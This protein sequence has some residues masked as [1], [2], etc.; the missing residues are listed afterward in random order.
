MAGA[1]LPDD[2]R[3]RA[4]LPAPAHPGRGRAAR[5]ERGEP[6]LVERPD[7]AR[8]RRLRGARSRTGVIL[9]ANQAFLDLVQ[10]GSEG[11]RSS[12]ERLAAL[13]RPAR[14]RPAGAAGQ[15]A[16]ARSR[17]RVL[18]HAHGELGPR[19]R[20]RS[21][22]SATPTASRGIVALLLRD[23]GPGPRPAP[24]RRRHAGA[25]WAR[26]TGRSARPRCASWSG[27][28]SARSSRHYIEAALDLTRGNRTAAAELLGLSRQSLY[29][30]LDRY[31]LDG[32]HGESRDR[33]ELMSPGGFR[34]G[35]SSIRDLAFGQADLSNCE[36][37]QIHLAGSIQ[38]HGALLVVREPDQAV[39][40]ASAN[41]AAFLGL[42]EEP[43]GPLPRPSSTAT[44]P[45]A[46]GR[47]S[48]SRWT[49]SRSRSAAG[50]ATGTQPFDGLLHRPPEGGL[51]IELER[52]GPPVDLSRQVE[53]GAA[54]ASSP[55]ASL[56][57]LCDE[58]ARIF[59]DLTGYDRVMVYRF[60]ERRPRRGLRRAARSRSS[61]PI[62]GN[63]YPAS[64]IPQIARRLYERNRVRVLVDVGYA[65][66]PL[67]PRLSPVTGRDLDMSLCFLR[68]M[69]P[70]HVQYLKNMGVAATL[71]V[72]AVVGG[73][74]WGLI[75]C[76]HYAPRFVHYEMRAVVRAAG[77]DGG[78]PHRGPRELR[79]GPGRAVRPAPRAAHDRGDLARR[80]LADGA[81]RQLAAAAA[82]AG[83]DRRR[84]PVRG[85]GPH[86]RRGARHAAAARDRRVAGRAAARARHRHGRPWASDEPAFAR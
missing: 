21:R 45:T 41:A 84:A 5:P 4:G 9:R 78:D 81:V 63:R 29:A 79:P 14:C 22:P 44:S 34:R 47:T 28:R 1:R 23:V 16:P 42:A 86:R 3:A 20:S 31:G 35:F 2:G 26:C 13:A 55:A 19:P 43:V 77:R 69:S 58:T 52:A 12:G 51:V 85:P 57:A 72:L 56:R 33:P 30:K 70:I 74:L 25:A 48:A 24:G 11:H 53:R 54:D 38:P 40:Q 73:R 18:D 64:D 7:R 75:A 15:R 37:E 71:V 67:R 39:V 27:T 32:G 61:S 10:V 50:S 83:R 8:A 68:S 62:L 6:V 76:H 59:K 80:R 82:A 65:P 66:V 17:Q 36:R 49:A 60:D 46:S